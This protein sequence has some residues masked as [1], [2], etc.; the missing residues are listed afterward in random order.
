V[1]AETA[2]A[3]LRDRSSETSGF[4]ADPS[5]IQGEEP[6][7]ASR[8]VWLNWLGHRRCRRVDVHVRRIRTMH[9]TRGQA[10]MVNNGLERSSQAN[11]PFFLHSKHMHLLIDS[12][13]HY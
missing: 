5:G 12:R 10:D 2:P 13:L 1:L 9:A 11:S 4:E 3:L 6:L 8:V 7:G